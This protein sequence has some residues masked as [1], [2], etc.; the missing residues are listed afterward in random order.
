MGPG[1]IHYYL[2]DGV[3]GEKFYLSL[4]TT[5][6]EADKNFAPSAAIWGLQAQRN[7]NPDRRENDV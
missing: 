1:E 4:L 5:A 7:N 3:E 2:F 6:E